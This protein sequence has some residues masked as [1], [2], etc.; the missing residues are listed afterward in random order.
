M[1][2]QQ[3]IQDKIDELESRQAELFKLQDEAL[4]R[5]QESKKTDAY[6]S[7]R[8]YYEACDQVK[9]VYTTIKTLKWILQN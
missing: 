5:Y 6:A 2:H 8:Q 9:E 1:K 3:Q 7:P 4:K